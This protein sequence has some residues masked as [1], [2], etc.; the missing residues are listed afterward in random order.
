MT[1][2]DLKEGEKG[3]ITKVK[4]R[5]AFRRRIIEMGFV[6][7]KLVEVIK[8]A[9]LQ[10]PVEYHILNYQVS[11]RNSE[12]HLVEV[13]TPEEAKKLHLKKE[14][15]NNSFNGV[16]SE[17]VLQ[18]SAK[19]KG[20]IIDVALVGNPNCGKT[21]LFNY[22]SGSKEHVGNYG[23]VTVDT[24]KAKFKQNGY[25][26][27]IADLPG[28][29]SLSAYSP[30]ELYVRKYIFGNVPDIVVNVIDASNLERNLY[31]TTQLIDMDIRMVI[32][33]NMHDEL[34]K[35]GDHF[36]YDSLAK[37]IGIPIVPTTASKGKGI[38][39]VFNKIIQVFEDNEPIVR[40]IHI[41][42]GKDV[43]QSILNIQNELWVNKS[44]T[45]KFSSRYY[46]IKLLEKDQSVDFS[47]S[48]QKN[49]ETIK[50]IVNKEIEHLESQYNEDTE[51]QISDAKYG[52]IAG[53]LKETFKE[54]IHKK[55]LKTETETID[56]FLTHRLFGFPI[57]FFFLWVMFMATF[58]LGDYPMRWIE[59]LVSLGGSVLSKSMPD[60]ILKDLFIDGIIG[61]VGGVI[62]FLPNILILFF[63]ISLMED[64]GYMARAAFIMDKLMHKIG[65]HGRSF[66]PLIMGFGCNVPAIMSSR[67]IKSRNDRL[68]TILINPFMSCSARLPVYILIAGTFF[69][70][71][72]ATVIFMI[73]ML[74]ILIAILVALVLKKTI[75]KSEEAP[76]VMELPPYR[77]PTLKATLRHMWNKGEQYLKK[78]G[79]VI[80]IASVIIWALGFFPRNISYSKDYASL[81]RHTETK[82]N[83]L[84]SES[85]PKQKDLLIN[86]KNDMINQLSLLQKNEKQE[87]SFIG[88][89]GHILEPV[90]QPLGFDWKMGV[91][92]FTGIAAKEV[93]VSTMGVLYLADD[94]GKN[95]SESLQTKLKSQRYQSGKKKGELVF[96]PVVALSFMAFILIYFPCV[97]VI[98]AVKKESGKWIWAAFTAIYTTGLAWLVSF[99]I[100]QVGSLF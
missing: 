72:A 78:M 62:V 5:G 1:L 11:L 99:L 33:L 65:L 27:N 24:R 61:G 66:I 73:Y 93:V 15:K 53:A 68:L 86:E 10:D 63:F 77:V 52:F 74:G 57:F 7:G 6:K 50:E 70:S 41:N 64:T 9:P 2:Y 29:Y 35:K 80:L 17:D 19:E 55:K 67:T 84:I 98:A 8:K 76:F 59:N 81:I 16:I 18:K 88:Q 28:T 44:L 36:D 40:H 69:P 39:E 34:V 95:T 79:G 60:G 20:K 51:T 54:N 37:M 32:V 75:L 83:K 3:V 56:T 14:I 21:T 58:K 26:F 96:T 13:I 23:G 25:T 89:I 90:I 22:A 82:Y 94:K 46:A 4:G 48:S 85:D 31:L 91:S 42:Y 47:V 45:D 97:A 71:Y 92:I 12:A 100:Y 49:Y 30:E 38:K 87:N 43:E